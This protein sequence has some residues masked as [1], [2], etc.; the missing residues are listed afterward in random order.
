MHLDAGELDAA[1]ALRDKVKA[2]GLAGGP[3]QTLQGH[4]E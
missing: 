2:H 3:G 4:A 1:V